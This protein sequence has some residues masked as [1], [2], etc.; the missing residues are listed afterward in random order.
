ML[1]V[2]QQLESKF[3]EMDFI[4]K[5][6]AFV[7]P[8]NRDFRSTNLD[9]LLARFPSCDE[10][11]VSREYARYISIRMWMMHF[12]TVVAILSSCGIH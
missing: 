11:K 1:T 8:R 5:K 9:E 3:P 7:N 6:F 12:I 4:L 10:S 2:A